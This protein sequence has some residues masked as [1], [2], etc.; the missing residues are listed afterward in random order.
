MMYNNDVV[1]TW[2]NSS[3]WLAATPQ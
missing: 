3:L 1:I 2:Y